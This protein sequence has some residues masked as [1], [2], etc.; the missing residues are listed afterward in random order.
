MTGFRGCAACCV[1]LAAAL[2]VSACAGGSGSQQASSGPI[3]IG[4]VASLTGNYAPLGKSDKAAAELLVKQVNDQGGIDGRKVQLLVQDDQTNPTQ[5]VLDYTRLVDQGVVAIEG[6]PFSTAELAMIPEVDK[7]KVPDVSLGADDHQTI[8]VHPYVYMTPPTSFQVAGTVLRYF[9]QQGVARIA[10]LYD[11]KNA[12]A[13]AGHDET[14]AL[15]AHFGVQVVQDEPFETS[16][17]N[18]SP[19]L[20]HVADSGAQFTLVWATGAPPVTITKQYRAAGI[21]IPLMMTAAEASPLYVTPAE[22]EAEDVYVEVT[23]G[24]VGPQVPATNGFK[25][26]IDDFDSAYQA[27]NGVHP[28]EF[29]FDAM[30]GMS[31]IFDA[32]RRKGASSDAIQRGLD[33][34]DLD[35]AQGHYTFSKDRHYGMPDSSNLIAQ[36]KDR[37]LVPVPA[38]QAV[39]DKAGTGPVSGRPS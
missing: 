2:I 24:V 33:S 38:A 3:K 36:V 11:T 27:A 26:K 35:T 8:P 16:Q 37:Q 25:K 15:A 19:Q 32:I 22:P 12:Y 9:K 30:A 28:P 10:M 14:K 4:L 13:V 21:A 5:A 1:I 31:L 20:T 39:L 17:T 6:T 7:R 34:S 18:F 23:L 29:A